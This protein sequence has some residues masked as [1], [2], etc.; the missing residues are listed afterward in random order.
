[1]A[2]ARKFSRARHE[3]KLNRREA[4]ERSLQQ[5]IY[6]QLRE[7]DPTALPGAVEMISELAA[8]VASQ[9]MAQ[10]QATQRA[11]RSLKD[12]VSEYGAE[13]VVQVVKEAHKDV[14][15]RIRATKAASPAVVDEMVL[16]DD[17]AG[18]VAGPTLLE[19]HFGIPRSTLYRWQKRN[20]V[21][22]L[23][24]RSSKKPVFPL[25]QF[26]DGR[27]A[28][29]IAE[30]VQAFDDPRAAWKWLTSGSLANKDGAPLEEL[31]NG[32]AASVIAVAQQQAP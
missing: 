14:R 9:L 1:M 16:A 22:W 26:V 29:G 23:N 11:L 24:T 4:V 19:R 20:E 17:W 25:K 3:I 31:L 12:E 6:T 13:I 7:E 15:D 5:T 32:D 27:P 8:V 2:D 18:P 21:V 28:I 30:I 10:T